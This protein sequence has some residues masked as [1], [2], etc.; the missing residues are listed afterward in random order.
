MFDEQCSGLVKNYRL[1]F[2]EMFEIG[3]NLILSA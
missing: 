3:V 2:N 1:F